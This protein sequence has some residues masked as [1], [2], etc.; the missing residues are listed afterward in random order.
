MASNRDKRLKRKVRHSYMLS[1][2]SIALVLFMLG[3]VGYGSFKAIRNILDPAL[4]VTLTVDI[5]NNLF[6]NEKEAI[7]NGIKALP[8]PQSITF[9]SKDER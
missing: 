8:E 4:R 2:A 1:T 5:A 3:I 6:D 7:V 9:V